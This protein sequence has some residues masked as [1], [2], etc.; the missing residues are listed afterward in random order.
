MEEYLWLIKEDEKQ[1][2]SVQGRLNSLIRYDFD[3][4]LSTTVKKEV[5][6]KINEEPNSLIYNRLLIWFFIQEEN[7]DLAL[8]HSISLD[9]RTRSE[10][11]AILDFRL[12]PH[13]TNFT[14]LPSGD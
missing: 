11:G 7:Y 4:T 12:P 5:L 3:K 13:K 14:I 6:R 10:E 2:Q 9:K 1:L 8:S